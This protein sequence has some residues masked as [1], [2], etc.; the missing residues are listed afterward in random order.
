MKEGDVDAQAAYTGD[1]LGIT[2]SRIYRFTDL[3]G[4]VALPRTHQT[5]YLLHLTSLVLA[6][7]VVVACLAIVLAVKHNYIIQIQS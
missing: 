4:P 7:A 6:H 2:E 5:S 3:R 1:K